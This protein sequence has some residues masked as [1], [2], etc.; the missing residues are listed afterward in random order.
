MHLKVWREWKP[1]RSDSAEMM[2]RC[3]PMINMTRSWH[4]GRIYAQ[5]HKMP[6]FVCDSI[7]FN[8]LIKTKIKYPTQKAVVR[9]KWDHIL[10]EQ[11]SIEMQMLNNQM[12]SHWLQEQAHYRIFHLWIILWCRCSELLTNSVNLI[13]WRHTHAHTE[14]LLNIYCN[15]PLKRYQWTQYLIEYLKWY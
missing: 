13:C 3:Q 8:F 9:R 1:H 10:E 11:I 14:V 7:V 15:K 2:V 5:I 6:N 12:D 4:F